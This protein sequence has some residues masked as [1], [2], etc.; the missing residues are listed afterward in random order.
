MTFLVKNEVQ[1]VNDLLRTRTAGDVMELGVELH[2]VHRPARCMWQGLCTP[3]F[4]P[5]L[6]PSLISRL[7]PVSGCIPTASVAQLVF[8][9]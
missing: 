7:P 6:G 1:A 3:T 8:N 9:H 5:P 4:S 2:A